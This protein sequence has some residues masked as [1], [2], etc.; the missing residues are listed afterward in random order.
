MVRQLAACIALAALLAPA[1]VPAAAAPVTERDLRALVTLLDPQIS[2]DG[3]RVAVVV[4]RADFEKNVYKN[5]LVLVDV[6]SGATRVLVKQRDDVSSPR[7][8]P[9]GDRLAYVATPEKDAAAKD[10]PHA[11]IAVLSMDGGEPVVITS[12]KQ[13]VDAFAWRPDGRAFAYLTHDPSRDEKRVK[14]KDDWFEITD[15][16]WTERSAPVPAHLWTVG[17]DSKAARGR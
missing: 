13:G 2:P 16:A 5:E 10:E 6:K 12:A 15:Q 1:A 14:A 8:A 17:A 4:R 3:K 7:W 9:G 11:Q